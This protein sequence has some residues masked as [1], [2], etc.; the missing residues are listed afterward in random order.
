MKVN[1]G[2]SPKLS[3]CLKLDMSGKGLQRTKKLCY[4]TQNSGLELEFKLRGGHFGNVCVICTIRSATVN[5]VNTDRVVQYAGRE[6]KRSA[7]AK[8]FPLL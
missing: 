6:F 7:Q 4:N 8:G 5:Y 1:P 2:E 3:L